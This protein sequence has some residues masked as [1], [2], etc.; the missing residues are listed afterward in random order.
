MKKRLNER[1]LKQ[2]Y[3]EDMVKRDR[4]NERLSFSVKSN[5]NSVF[6]YF[7]TSIDGLTK[8]QAE[9]S[10]DEYGKN[11]VTSTNKSTVIKRLYGA[12]INPFTLVLIVLAVVSVFTDI[13]FAQPDDKN[14]ITVIII[15]VMVMISGVLR[16]VQEAKSER[17]SSKLSE[18][19]ETTACIKRADCEKE[20]IP[21]DEIVVGDIV[22]LSAGDLVPADVRIITAKDLFINQS[23]LT[24]E[25]EP[26][27]K[28]ANC[29]DD[30]KLTESTCLAF[31]G[32]T[33]ISG[34][35]IAV[36][37]AVGT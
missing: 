29:C 7:N 21:V 26:I 17:A 2:Q 12:F 25:S 3:A 15:S 37:I 18:M 34:S 13:V 22:Y 10:V 32:S 31:M 20:E 11:I 24:G 28:T 9:A 5:I 19:I 4:I 14:P 6:D 36:V 33:V 30:T 8:R 35:G 27:E 1:V 23:A 16:F